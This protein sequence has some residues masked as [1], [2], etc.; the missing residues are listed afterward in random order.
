MIY[1]DLSFHAERIPTCESQP[2]QNE[3]T[4]VE[5]EHEEE[6][7]Y[8]KCFYKYQGKRC[9]GTGIFLL[10]W[11]TKSRISAHIF[12]YGKK[13]APGVAEL[14]FFRRRAENESFFGIIQE[15]YRK[16]KTMA[17]Q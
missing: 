13:I 16:Y 17:S 12:L 14:T 11:F 4:C 5:D 3:G 8:C 2:C 7:F 15:K 9:Q 6:G 1:I 10:D